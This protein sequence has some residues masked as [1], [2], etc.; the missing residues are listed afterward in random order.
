M[1]KHSGDPKAEWYLPS[2]VAELVAEGRA[3][4][5]VLPTTSSWFGVTYPDDRPRVASALARLVEQGVYPRD[6]FGR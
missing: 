3:T 2:V 1:H 6:L 4:V 5:R